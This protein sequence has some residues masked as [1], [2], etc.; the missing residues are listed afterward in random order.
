MPAG[1]DPV[2]PQGREITVTVPQEAGAEPDYPLGPRRPAVGRRQRRSDSR[3][4][5][6]N[7]HFSASL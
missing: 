1:A 7:Q 4:V 2:Q 3:L 5:D 6:E